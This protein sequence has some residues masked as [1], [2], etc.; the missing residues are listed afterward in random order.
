MAQTIKQS[1]ESLITEIKNNPEKSKTQFAAKSK[2]K[3]GVQVQSS[4]RHFTFNA[5]EDASVGGKDS[6]ANPLEYLAGSLAA[7]QVIT[8]KALASLKNIHLKDVQVKTK[9]HTDLNGFLGID[10]SI[11]PG[12]LKVEFE[13]TIESDEDPKKLQA[14]AKQ[15]EKLCPLLDIF[16]NPTKVEGEFKFKNKKEKAA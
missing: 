5:D 3:E 4:T 11:R 12:Y 9:A 15:V 10:K 14:L 1:L 8:Y 6:A 13:T 16:S 7:C 2:L